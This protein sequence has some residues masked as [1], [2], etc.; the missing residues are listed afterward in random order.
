MNC[1]LLPL[2]ALF[3]AIHAHAQQAATPAD[4]KPALKLQIIE[5]VEVK[6]PDRSIFYQRAAPPI[7]PTPRPSTP[8]PEATPLSLAERAAAEAR[9]KK[10]FEVLMISATVYDCRVTELR[11]YFGQ[12]E[13]RAWS[14]IDFNYL[15]GQGEIETEDSIY[16]LIMGLG[17][18]TAESVAAANERAAA[19]GWNWHKELP[20][21][22]R[23]P[24]NRAEYILAGG[25]N[26]PK[27]PSEA[28][29]PLDAL[30]SYYEANRERL[31]DEYVKREA[32]QLARE[33]WLKEHPPIPKDTVIHFWPKKSRNY[34]TGG[35]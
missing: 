2:A 23:F 12:R 8:V 4:T 18:D 13:Y 25:S 6:L 24:P 30:H 17:N 5:G 35:K 29:A 9:A 34:P 15:A 3:T 14:N 19:E 27:P 22:D 31:A 1:K 21:A 28:L 32:A 20:P 7:P 16:W 11:W 33:K 26:D 10:K